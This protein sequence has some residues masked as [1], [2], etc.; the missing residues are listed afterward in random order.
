[1][2]NI[3]RYVLTILFI[4]SLWINTLSQQ[5]DDSTYSFKLDSIVVT[6]SRYPVTLKTSP[7]SID[8]V[9]DQTL[10]SINNILTVKDAFI[11]VPG[12][13]VNNRFNQ[14]QGDKI[15]IR[16]IGTRTQFGVRG[17]K[18]LLDGVPLTL[19][20]GQSSLNNLNI[21]AVKKI[22]IIRGPSSVLYGNASGGVIYFDSKPE[23]PGNF[24]ITPG[25]T[26]GSFNYIRGDVDLGGNV[27]DGTY[28]LNA[29]TSVSDGFR[30]HSN[31][32]FSGINLATEHDLTD[33]LNFTTVSNFY[34]SPYMLNPSSLN[35]EDSENNPEKVRSFIQNQGAGKKVLQFQFGIG[36]DY[37]FSSSSNFKTTLYGAARSLFNSIPGRIIEL[38]RLTGGLRTEYTT[39][40]SMLGTSAK[41]I[42]G[43]DL[44]HQNDE[45]VEYINLGVQGEPSD[46]EDILNSIEYGDKILEQNEKV[47]GLGIFSIL[48]LALTDKLNLSVGARFDN[49]IFRADDKFLSDGSDD[50]GEVTLDEVSPIIGLSYNISSPLNFYGNYSTSFQTPTTNELSNKPDGTGGFNQNLL[51]ENI[52]IL[53]AGLRGYFPDINIYY[54]A[55][56]Y[57]LFI[58]NMLIPY[59]VESDISEEVYYR[60][61]GESKNTGLELSVH[62]QPRWNYYFTFSYSYMNFIYEDFVVEETINDTPSEINLAGNYV[63][64]IPQNTLNFTSGYNVLSNLLAELRFNWTDSYYAND[65]N[66][67]KPG[68]DGDE[69]DFVNN[70][71]VTFGLSFLYTLPLHT[72][73]LN[74]KLGIENIFDVRYNGS[75]VPNASGNNF[76]EPASGRAIYFTVNAAF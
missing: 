68:I 6:A 28:S 76:F 66:G 25:I 52:N 13:I 63:P 1:M 53:E 70:E 32:R 54:N 74:L 26:G 10:R 48:A 67:P 72:F 37:K 18:I 69:Y 21:A 2:I 20:D 27:F 56:V 31:S 35:K 49:F 7:L 61:A 44:E 29:Y 24:Y 9:G 4:A 62:W 36:L 12:V 57:S 55:A 39:T 17:I 75:I 3:K 22:E 60:N 50:S 46:P 51:P 8:V 15:T 45:R 40:F 16:G 65:Y 41:F 23:S 33:K 14:A 19:P 71:Y 5:D 30:N 42:A 64:G 47:T 58:K 43:L 59:Q 73:K 38:D 11:K 34:Y